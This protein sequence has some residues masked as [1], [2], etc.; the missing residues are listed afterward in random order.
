MADVDDSI[1]SENG[2]VFVKDDQGH[3][4]G[5]LFERPA[6]IRVVGRS[7]KPKDS[8]LRAA[9]KEQ[10]RDYASRGFTTVTELLYQRQKQFDSLLEAESLCEDCPVRLALYRRVQGPDD[11]NMQDNEPNFQPNEKLWEAGVKIIADGSPHC[12]TAAVREPFLNTNLTKTL[13]FA[14]APCY[15]SLNYTTEKLL[16]TVEF[17]HKQG[18]QIAIHAHGERAVDQVIS[19][20]EQVRTEN[21]HRESILST[22]FLFQQR[23]KIRNRLK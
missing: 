21:R 10:W 13:G 19:V 22:F 5:Q 15:G 2:G 16:E 1:E 3:L 7:P 20:Y 18:T 4:T 9:V 14:D 6:L 12:G 8:E 11:H 23:Y 17:F